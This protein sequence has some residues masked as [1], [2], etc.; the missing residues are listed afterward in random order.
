MGRQADTWGD[1]KKRGRNSPA[2]ENESTPWARCIFRGRSLAA[3]GAAAR[4]GRF[5]PE[6]VFGT[7][8]GGGARDFSE[9]GLYHLAAGCWEGSEGEKA[10][11][12]GHTHTAESAAG[13]DIYALE[14][15]DGENP[16]SREIGDRAESCGCP[17]S[18]NQGKDRG[19][20]GKQNRSICDRDF[21]MPFSILFIF[22]GG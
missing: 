14:A 5:S 6:G 18:A 17:D 8:N 1:G 15:G 2:S 20:R 9:C 16:D 10:A 4:G 11:G 21:P 13:K 22:L 7:E 12:G 19:M 3:H